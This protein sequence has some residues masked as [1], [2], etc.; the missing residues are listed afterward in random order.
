MAIHQNTRAAWRTL[1]LEPRK[2]AVLEAYHER[3]AMTDRQVA[4]HLG[5]HDMNTVRPVI[6]KLL[7]ADVLVEVGDAKCSTTKR[8][9]RLVDIAEGWK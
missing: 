2:A 1:R 5:F 7:Q 4:K 3:G 6:T 8:T 9:V